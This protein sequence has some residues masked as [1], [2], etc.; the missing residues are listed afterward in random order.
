MQRTM[1]G[2]G[3]KQNKQYVKTKKTEVQSDENVYSDK[4]ATIYKTGQIRSFKI[5]L[6]YYFLAF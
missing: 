3:K 2:S 5:K 6:L 1:D 4:K